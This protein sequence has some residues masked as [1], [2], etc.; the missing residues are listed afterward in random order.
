[1]ASSAAAWDLTGKTTTLPSGSRTGSSSTIGGGTSTSTESSTQSQAVNKQNTP[2][3]ALSSLEDLIKQLSDRPRLSDEQAS[4]Q[5]PLSVRVFDPRAGWG[6]DMGGGRL[7]FGPQAQADAQRWDQQQL[8]KRQQAQQESGIIQGGTAASGQQ[9]ADRQNLA[10][11]LQE[12]RAGYSKEAAFADAANLAGR[13][14]RQLM[15]QLMP[16]I[17]KAIESSGTSGGAV[18]G[19]LANDAAAR[20]AEAQAQLGLQAATQYGQISNQMSQI[21]AEL[22]SSLPPEMQALLQALGISKGTIEQGVTIGSGSSTKTVQQSE[23]KQGESVETQQGGA[24]LPQIA[25]LKILGTPN[26]AA[27]VI[28]SSPSLDQTLTKLARA[29]TYGGGYQF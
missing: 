13:S 14:Q 23:T 16:Q 1:M 3:F 29:S 2:D 22:S 9:T 25:G 12:G 27:P 6:Y 4:A 18:S 10:R 19:L 7:S 5:F 28:G 24:S 20:V 21:L 26:V 15:E 11:S 17:T 8:A